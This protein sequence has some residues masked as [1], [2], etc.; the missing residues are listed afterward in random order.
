LVWGSDWPHLSA[1]NHDLVNDADL[2]EWL[3][4]MDIDART[5]EMILVDNPVKLYGFGPL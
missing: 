1:F 4:E 2:L 5:K 3:L